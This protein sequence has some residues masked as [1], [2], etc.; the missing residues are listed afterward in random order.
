MVCKIIAKEGTVLNVIISEQINMNLS[1]D[2]GK[3]ALD[4]LQFFLLYSKFIVFCFIFIAV[5]IALIPLEAAIKRRSR[6]SF[7]KILSAANVTFPGYTEI[8]C[9]SALTC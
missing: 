2:K 1:N 9:N 8:F 3:N 7:N 5:P 4:S 6:A